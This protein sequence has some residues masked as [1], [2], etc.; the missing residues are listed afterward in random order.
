MKKVS[1][2][3]VGFGGVVGILIGGG[4]LLYALM[5]FLGSSLPDVDT[6]WNDW[7][8]YRKDFLGHRGFTHSFLLNFFL[9]VLSFVGSLIDSLFT[10]LFFLFLGSFIH[11]V[12]DA[13]SP[14]GVPIY[15]S[16]YPRLR[17]PIYKTGSLRDEGL[18]FVVAFF[19]VGF[20]YFYKVHTVEFKELLEVLKKGI[21]VGLVWLQQCE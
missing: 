16:Y 1:H 13:F 10:P 7:N 9:T 11:V 4:N 18:A 8:V 2:K 20:G 12:L 5:F 14:S 21:E 19:L 3:I 15:L 17:Y 6:Y